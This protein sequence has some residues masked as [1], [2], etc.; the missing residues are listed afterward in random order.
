MRRALEE[1]RAEED[2]TTASVVPP[3]R[4]AS[5]RVLFRKEGVLAGVLPFDETF[6]ILGGGVETLWVKREGE[7]AAAGETVCRF[8]GPAAAVLRGERVALNFLMRLSG[9]ATLTASFVRAVA[10]TG[11]EILDTRKTTPGLRLLEKGAVRAGGGVNHRMDL[12]ALALIKENHIRIAGGIDAAVERVRRNAP[13]VGIE[14]EVTNEKELE[15]ALALSVDRVMLDNFD[16]ADVEKSVKRAR[17]EKNPPYVELSGGMTVEKA[18]KAA[19]LG[20]NGISVGA[21]THS[22]PAADLSLLFEAEGG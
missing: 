15:E 19:L 12:S 16:L 5:G 9:V 20:V 13:G 7:V 1:D 11:V 10:G 21:L 2:V 6:R 22:A 14:V 18:A 3:D 8:K 4:A 17:R